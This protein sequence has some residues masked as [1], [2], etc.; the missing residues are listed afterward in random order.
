MDEAEDLQS[1]AEEFEK[2]E[3]GGRRDEVGGW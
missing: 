2:D 3:E 1:V